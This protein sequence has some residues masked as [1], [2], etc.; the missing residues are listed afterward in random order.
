MNRA[1]PPCVHNYLLEQKFW[2]GGERGGRGVGASQ[3]LGE[4]TK[5]HLAHVCIGANL[6]CLTVTTI[7]TTRNHCYRTD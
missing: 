1:S 5:G 6:L 7:M 2:G 3:E 4:G